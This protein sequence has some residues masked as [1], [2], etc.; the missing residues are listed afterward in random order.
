MPNT[1]VYPSFFS[2][3]VGSGSGGGA[4]N[5][6]YLSDNIHVAWLTTSHTPNY[7]SH[8]FFDDVVAN[9]GS[10]SGYTAGGQAL[11]S[12]TITITAANSWGTQRANSTAY[13]VGDLVRPATGNGFVYVCVVA[14]TS[15]GSIP[16][17]STVIGRETSDGTVVWMT[18]GRNVVVYDAA[19]PSWNPV[20]LTNVRY[21]VVYDRTPST[22]ATR[23]LICLMDFDSGQNPSAGPLTI[24]IPATGLFYIP[25][26]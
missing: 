15:G 13:A 3:I 24:T 19:D 7:D 26:P 2:Q 5:V 18:A 4:P 14:G 8:D 12:K 17:Y 9:E 6:D 16:T 11:A 20:T 1:R 10:G 23:P 25:V 21:A 22:D